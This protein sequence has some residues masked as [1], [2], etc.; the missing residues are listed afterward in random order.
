MKGQTVDPQDQ[1]QRHPTHE[2]AIPPHRPLSTISSCSTSPPGRTEAGPR[3]TPEAQQP[4]T[5][6]H[7]GRL[8]GLIGPAARNA[9][10]GPLACFGVLAVW[11]SK[12]RAAPRSGCSCSLVCRAP[13]TPSMHPAPRSLQPSGRDPLRNA[14]HKEGSPTRRPNPPPRPA[15]TKPGLNRRGNAAVPPLG[16]SRSPASKGCSGATHPAAPPPPSRPP[17][18]PTGGAARAPGVIEA[19][20]TNPVE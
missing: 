2:Q 9:S 3:P 8:I 16:P 19:R 17:R 12:R 18:R 4:Q 5:S 14:V 6:S 11:L 7:H 13:V 20:H 1:G 15:A 10:S